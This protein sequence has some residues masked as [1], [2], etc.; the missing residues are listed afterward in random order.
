MSSKPSL[1][2]FYDATPKILIRRV[3][4]RQDRLMA[5]YTMDRM[6]FKKDL[7]PFI[8]IS[9]A[10]NPLFVLGIINSRLIS[11]LYMNTS[12]IAMK[13]DFR[14]TT[15]AELRRLPIPVAGGAK[16]ERMVTLVQRMLELHK[17]LA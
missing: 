15:L 4:N 2:K 9:D 11:Y 12:S 13:D 6:V 8:V 14:Q 1:S 3:I 5:G 16:C 10:W 17:Q 7:N